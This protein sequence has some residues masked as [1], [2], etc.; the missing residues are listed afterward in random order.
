MYDY[1]GNVSTDLGSQYW[2]TFDPYVRPLLTKDIELHRYNELN[3]SEPVF[4]EQDNDLWDRV[5]KH[6]GR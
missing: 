5:K 3:T 2:K 6:Q 1:A 4:V